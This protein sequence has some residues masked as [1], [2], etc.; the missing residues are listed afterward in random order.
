ME[1]FPEMNENSVKYSTT[2]NLRLNT[3]WYAALPLF[4][5]ILTLSC[6]GLQ[7]TSTPGRDSTSC[8]DKNPVKA[9]ENRTLD[10]GLSS[11]QE[12]VLLYK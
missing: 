5:C 6:G 10:F 4:S 12:L 2:C 7:E 8:V 3:H 11:E 1:R 9:S